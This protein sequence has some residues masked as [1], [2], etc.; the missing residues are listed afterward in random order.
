[1][2]EAMVA[3]PNAVEDPRDKACELRRRHGEH[4]RAYVEA[5]IEAAET[6]GEGAD[7]D[8]WRQVLSALNQDAG[9]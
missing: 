3:E 8:E 7:A 5:R 1:M 2:S 4:A 6:A 9:D